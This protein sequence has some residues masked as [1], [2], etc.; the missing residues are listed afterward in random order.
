[1]L[2][3]TISG[4]RSPF[5]SAT[6]TTI[7]PRSRGAWKV[8]SP[9][10]SMRADKAIK[11]IFAVKVGIGNQKM[12]STRTSDRHRRLKRA[13]TIPQTKSCGTADQQ[14]QLVV[15]VEIADRKGSGQFTRLSV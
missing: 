12:G 2:A 5:R 4:F 15:P 13:I 11:S 1:M 10:P 3:V 7:A 6:S 9:L 8:P 14:V